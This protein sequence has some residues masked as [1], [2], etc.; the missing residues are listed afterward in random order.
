MFVC[1]Q[2]S[3]RSVSKSS[4]DHPSLS[5][6][7]N[8]KQLPITFLQQSIYSRALLFAVANTSLLFAELNA[9]S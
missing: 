3:L 5:L 4:A 7:G 8:E 9:A 1:R 6:N 2:I